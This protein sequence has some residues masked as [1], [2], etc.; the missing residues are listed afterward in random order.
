MTTD[1]H[2]QRLA[3]LQALLTERGLDLAVLHYATDLY[4]YTGSTQPLYL[5][6]PRAGQA[7]L[8]ARKALARIAEEAPALP[9]HPFA[10]SKELAAVFAQYPAA[11]V[12]LTLDTL[13]AATF[14]RLR[15]CFAEAETVDIAADVRAL[16]MVKDEEEIAT[17]ARAGNI[18]S[19]LPA[20][21]RAH[22]TRRVTELELSAALEFFFRTAG[23]DLLIRSRREG[24]EMSAC[25]ICVA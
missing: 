6:V 19:G 23:H 16:R 14:Q 17:L 13:S 2:A 8:L 3:T 20:L 9:L 4:Y 21:V 24:V 22:V 25:G 11:R 1:R 18:L 10:G 5:L 15:P 7:C 12:G